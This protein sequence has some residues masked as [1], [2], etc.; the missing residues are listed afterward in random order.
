MAEWTCF[1][2]RWR[3][4]WRRRKRD[5]ELGRDLATPAH[6]VERECKSASRMVVHGPRCNG[7]EKR[8]ILDLVRP[9]NI[10]STGSEVV[11]HYAPARK[12]TFERLPRLITSR[13]GRTYCPLPRV[14]HPLLFLLLSWR[15]ISITVL[16]TARV[17]YSRLN[18]KN[19]RIKFCHLRTLNYVKKNFNSK[20]TEEFV[21]KTKNSF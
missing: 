21:N 8:D 6:V 19:T 3:W 13:L 17:P 11:Y 7:N 2:R 4:R 5:D 15:S 16:T 14:F 12:V 1:Q 9:D 20:L 18:L 10:R